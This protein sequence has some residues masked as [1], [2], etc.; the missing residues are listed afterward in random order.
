ML[1]VA[2]WMS[3]LL[4]NKHFYA[5]ITS[6]LLQIF[7]SSCHFHC[8]YGF[9]SLF[10]AG[11]SELA[12]QCDMKCSAR[13]LV[14]TVGAL[15]QS[16]SM[17]CACLSLGLSF[18]CIFLAILTAVSSSPLDWGRCWRGRIWPEPADAVHFWHANQ[19]P[20]SIIT[21]SAALSQANSALW[22]SVIEIAA[23]FLMLGIHFPAVNKS[24]L[25]SLR[26]E[27][28][29]EDKTSYRVLFNL[30]PQG[31]WPTHSR[32]PVDQALSSSKQD[33]SLRELVEY[34]HSEAADSLSVLILVKTKLETL[35][36]HR[37]AV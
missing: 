6:L 9:E 24:T 25:H 21:I 7:N 2:Y 10:A 20:L 5:S 29:N 37:L 4:S 3:F 33:G 31:H 30:G 1:A 18:Q 35:T 27:G 34:L 12:Q 14:C 28:K 15:L 17:V 22:P 13:L 23:F 36:E 32:H 16:S 19:G 8:Y 26:R 11:N